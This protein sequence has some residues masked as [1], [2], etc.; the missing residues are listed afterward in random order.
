MANRIFKPEEFTGKPDEDA[1]EWL[2]HFNK[3][4]HANE[5]TNANKLRIVPVFL[6]EAAERWWM[7]QEIDRWARNDGTDGLEEEFIRKFD[8]QN[9]QTKWVDRFERI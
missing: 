6:K 5:W 3:V 7:R 1:V 8:R 2:A 9:Q 4:A